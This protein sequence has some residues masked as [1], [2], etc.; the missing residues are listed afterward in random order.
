MGA[1]IKE[2]KWEIFNY[3]FIKKAIDAALE[4]TASAMDACSRLL[5]LC[6]QE[7]NFGNNDFGYAFDDLLWVSTNRSIISCRTNLSTQW[8]CPTSRGCFLSS[9]RRR[10]TREQ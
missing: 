10:C 3:L 8:M 5:T 4:R 9:L 7:F 2:R 1:E 6:T